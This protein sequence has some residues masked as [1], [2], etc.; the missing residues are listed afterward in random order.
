M[1]GD[2]VFLISEQ[3]ELLRLVIGLE[4]D[5]KTVEEEIKAKTADET[6]DF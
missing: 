2:D 4:E 1:H 3:T 6:A 5:T